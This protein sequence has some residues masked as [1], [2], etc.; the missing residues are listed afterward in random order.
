MA[1]VRLTVIASCF[2]ISLC[3]LPLSVLAEP[4]IFLSTQLNPVEEADKM[5]K[6]ILKEFKGDVEFEPYDDRAVFKRLATQ[7][8]ETAKR[9]GLFGAL[10]GDFVSLRREDALSGV[11]DFM[12]RLKGRK[13]IESFLTLGRMGE[14]RQYFIPWMQATYIMAANRKALKYLPKGADIN[15]L[16]YEQ[17]RQWAVNM[18]KEAGEG[19]LGFPVGTNGLMH[20]FFQ[21]YLYPSFTGST[22]RRFR[23][24]EAV[25]MWE[26]FRDLWGSVNSRSLTFS[27]MDEPLL[28]GEVWVAWDHT[29]RIIDVFKKRP[30]DF[31]AFPVP[32]GPTG[33][34]FMVV[35]AGLGLPKDTSDRAAALDLIEYL[36]RPEV[37][38]VTLNSVGFYPVVETEGAMEL[39]AGLDRINQA[40]SRQGASREAVVALLP[41]GLA[42][43]GSVFNAVY[44]EA[45]SKIVLRKRNASDIL[46]VQAAKLEKIFIETGAQCWPP[47][48]PSEGP[49]PVE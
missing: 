17:L 19:M 40:I 38:V 44:I 27:R 28:A 32:I 7:T 18:K 25:F 42:G 6:V 3:S 10:H 2:F 16:T 23:S 39:P 45:F 15:S 26:F 11:D 21:G 47:D 24:A 12:A 4:I 20:R 31:I 1:F 22:A 13:F 5:R 41:V 33:R 30:D 29:A 43:K 34:G 46:A 9:P 36:T 8:A 48:E 35:L 37:Q 49:C 14:D